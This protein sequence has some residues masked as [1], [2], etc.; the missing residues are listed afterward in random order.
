VK[1]RLRAYC[2]KRK[3]LDEHTGEVGGVLQ[4]F[5]DLPPD[6]GP[7]YTWVRMQHLDE[8]EDSGDGCEPSVGSF[9][10]PGRY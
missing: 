1:R 2:L 5:Y 7:N 8:R 3:Y 4:F 6:L 9:D 10:N